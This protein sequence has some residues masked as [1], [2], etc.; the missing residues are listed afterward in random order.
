MTVNRD[1]NSGINDLRAIYEDFTDCPADGR[2]GIK[3]LGDEIAAAQLKLQARKAE[4]KAKE[5]EKAYKQRAREVRIKRRGPFE[6]FGV[7]RGRTGSYK[8][9]RMISKA[10]VAIENYNTQQEKFIDE[11]RENPESAMAWSISMFSSVAKYRVALVVKDYFE[12]GASESD[13]IEYMNDQVVRM[14]RWPARSTSPTSNLM[15]QEKLAAY[16]EFIAD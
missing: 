14:S 11:L 6:E 1:S 3:K 15:E 16:A 4:I 2:W 5:V 10:K 12:S 9:R 8:F 13:I 7:Y